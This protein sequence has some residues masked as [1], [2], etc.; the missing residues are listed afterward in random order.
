MACVGTHVR[1]PSGL[2]SLSSQPGIRCR[3]S[4]RE[5]SPLKWGGLVFETAFTQR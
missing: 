1:E 5:G 2:H 4:Q 3:I